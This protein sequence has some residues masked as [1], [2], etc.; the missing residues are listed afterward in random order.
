MESKRDLDTKAKALVKTSPDEAL[1][2]YQE[3]WTNYS[4]EFNGWDAFYTLQAMKGAK[5]P[6]LKWG[7]ELAE[8][9]SEEKVGSMYAWVIFQH[10][11][12][13]KERQDIIALDG[14]ISELPK[15]CD[16]KDLSEQEDFPCPTTLSIIKLCEAHAENLFNAKRINDLLE[17]LDSAKL[18]PRS[19]PF[20]TQEGKEV[21]PSPDLEKYYSLKTKAL[22]RLER[23]EECKKLSLK[24]LDVLKEFHYNNDLWMK[25]RVA[26][27]EE[28]LGNHEV[29]E[30]LF[31][32]LLSSRE[33]SD[34][35]FL[36]RDISEVYFEKGDFAKAWKFAV[37]STFYG[38]E[39]G[40]MIKLY[41]HQAKVLFRLNRAP[42]GKLMAELIASILKEE[43][44][45]EKQEYSKLFAF[46][47]I[48]TEQVRPLQEVL[49][50]A[51]TFWSKERYGNIS[52]MSGEIIK[53]HGNK[54]SG[55]IKTANGEKLTFG[56][57]DLLKKARDLEALFGAEVRFYPMRAFDN[58]Q[59]AEHIEILI[60]P[61][62]KSVPTEV[63]F[64]KGVLE[65][66]VKN[67]ADFGVFIKIPGHGDGLLHKSKVPTQWQENMKEAF[68]AGKKVKVKIEKITDKG[69]S[70]QLV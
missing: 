30:S 41:L 44:W 67:V 14:Y 21:I 39:P 49:R 17:L 31:K 7:R 51:K 63:S 61:E 40:F 65:G 9:F 5:S 24:G 4:E 34:K 57:K 52:S 3:I 23:Y 35:W 58:K 2:L 62:R 50:E 42:E 18:S 60:M 8:K 20:K 33:G 37:D 53:I 1:K 29:S 6:S 38:N 16:Q 36:Y 26:I 47:K 54:K 19:K 15:F 22:L 45:K 12:K 32:D 70:L 68:P 28:G 48:D 55:L 43:G 66:T 11:L 10:G 69:T 64:P 13:G 25:M 27:S 56:R 59:V 46:Y